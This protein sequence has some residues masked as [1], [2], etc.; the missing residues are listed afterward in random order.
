[1]TPR[2]VIFDMDGLLVDSEPLWVRAEIEVFGEVGLVLREDDCA[3]TKGLRT[4]AVV[5]YWHARRPWTVVPSG[6]PEALA[7]DAAARA[8]RAAPPAEVERRLVARVAALVGAEGR[9]LPGV[10]SALAAA[11]SGGR[12]VALA[13]SSPE[14]VIRAAL[15]RLGLEGA[16]DAVHSAQHEPFGKPHPGVFLT[17]ADRLGV[18]PTDC[19]VLEDSLTGVIAAK[20][21][22][23]ACVAVP[24]DH[25]RQDPRFVLADA[26]IGSLEELTPALVA[27]GGVRGPGA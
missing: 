15:A 2:A 3:L 7:E 13:S 25:P 18:P 17:T 1:V 8:R 24:F 10:A 5:A 23:M 26:V 12:R 6:A 9:A 22:R 16:F 27:S 19:L 21:A 20:A 14:L 11:R 4:D